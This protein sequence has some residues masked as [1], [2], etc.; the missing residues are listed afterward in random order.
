MRLRALYL[1]C[2]G[3]LSLPDA[4]RGR[5]AG[6]MQCDRRAHVVADPHA[7]GAGEPRPSRHGAPFDHTNGAQPRHCHR[8]KAERSPTPV[9]PAPTFSERGRTGSGRFKDWNGL[10]SVHPASHRDRGV[11]RRAVFGPTE[12]HRCRQC[13]GSSRPVGRLDISM[14]QTALS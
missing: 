13:R 3:E 7:S 1:T 8:W 11:R 4:M 6:R 2:C 5:H 14:H 9:A 12:H 10:V